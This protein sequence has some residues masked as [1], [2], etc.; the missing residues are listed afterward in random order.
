M[1]LALLIVVILYKKQLQVFDGLNLKMRRNWLGFL[2]YML[3][4]QAIMS[5]VCVV[6][7]CQEILGMRKRW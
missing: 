5:P 1:P 4:Y 7:Y 6:G 2:V 3:V